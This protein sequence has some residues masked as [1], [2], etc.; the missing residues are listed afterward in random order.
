MISLQVGHFRRQATGIPHNCL[1]IHGPPY[2]RYV[3][4]SLLRRA[5][6]WTPLPAMMIAYKKIWFDGCLAHAMI[7]VCVSVVANRCRPDMN[8]LYIFL[9]YW[10]GV[11]R[12]ATAYFGRDWPADTR[13]HFSRVVCQREGNYCR[14]TPRRIKRG[15]LCG[16]RTAPSCFIFIEADT[17]KPLS[18]GVTARLANRFLDSLHG[19]VFF[20]AIDYKT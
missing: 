13:M 18:G 6:D 8:N 17:L 15:M 7:V 14:D 11:S 3:R 16:R 12:R 20:F 4:S 10:R 9:Y 2:T 5:S 1:A 19:V